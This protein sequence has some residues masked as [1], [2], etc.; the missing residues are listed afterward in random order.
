MIRLARLSYI[1]SISVIALIILALLALKSGAVQVSFADLWSAFS[2]GADAQHKSVLFGIRLPRIIGAIAVGA[3]LSIAGVLLQSL[4]RNP[5][6]DGGVVGTS[7]GAM[8]FSSLF[9]VLPSIT[10]SFHFNASMQSIFAFAGAMLVSL[11]VMKMNSGRKKLSTSGIVLTG[12]AI[13]AWA[14]AI[15]GILIFVSTESQLRSLMFWTL[16]SLSGLNYQ[17]IVLLCCALLVVFFGAIRCAHAM[18]QMALGD[19][20]A[21]LLGVNVKRSKMLIVILAALAIGV[22]VTFTGLIG[23]VGLVMPHVARMVVGFDHKKVIIVSALFGGFLLLL[24]DTISRTIVIPSELPIG[25]L[26]GL[27]GVPFFLRLILKHRS[28]I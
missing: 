28:A 7:A 5:L 11:L 9:I 24:A 6:A 23:F 15:T 3:L 8:L 22:A 21:E 13:G 27:I 25:I 19:D 1:V 10:T 26:T 14:S 2:N 16:G 18:N 12:I 4:L 20:E 17:I